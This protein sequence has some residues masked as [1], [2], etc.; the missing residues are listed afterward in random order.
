VTILRP[1]LPEAVTP[2]SRKRLTVASWALLAVAGFVVYLELARTRA[3]D[4]DGAANALQAWD[5]LHGNLLLRG[6]RVSDVSFYTTEL[7]QYMLIELVRGLNSGVV[8]IAAAMTYTLAVLTAALVAKGTATGREGVL[9]AVTA[10]GIMLAPQLGDG[11]NTLVSSPDHIG[12]AVPILLAW[13]ILERGGRRWYIAVAVALLLGWTTVGDVLTLYVGVAPVVLICAYRAVRGGPRWFEISLG[14]GTLACGLAAVGVL[15][16]IHAAGGF[17][18]F[19][20]HSQLAPLPE[21]LGHNLKVVADGLLLLGG[22]SFSGLSGRANYAFAALHFAGLAIAA[23]AF[24]VTAWCWFRSDLVDQIIVVAII[25]N[26]AGY[27]LTTD[28]VSVGTTREMNP[29]LPL[30]AALAGRRL[31]PVLLHWSKRRILVPALSLVLA[32]YAA[33]LA[34]EVAAPPAPPMHANLANWLVRH[35]LTSGLSGY[36]ASSV[37]TVTTGAGVR[38]VVGDSHQGRFAAGGL[39]TNEN[40]Y[41]PHEYRANFVVLYPSAGDYGGFN[42]R[43]QALASFG[44]PVRVYHAARCTIM[45]WNKNLLA[46]L[47]RRLPT[48]AMGHPWG[49]WSGAYRGEQVG[50]SVVDGGLQGAAQHRHHR[51][52]GR[53]DSRVRR[54]HPGHLG[55]DPL[56]E[57][58]PARE[59]HLPAEH[60]QPRIE[61]RAHRSDAERHPVRQF[62]EE[63]VGAG[64][65]GGPLGPL[66]PLGSLGGGDRGADRF[67]RR[68]R[69]EAVRAGQHADR[70]RASQPLQP[71]ARRIPDISRHRRTWHREVTD[72]ASRPG[73]TPVQLSAQHGR[74]S[75]ADPDPDQHEVIHA[76]G[77]TAGMLRHRGEVHVVLDHHGTTQRAAQ[78]GEHPLV[79]GRQVY[80]EPRVTGRRVHDPWRADDERAQRAHRHTGLAAGTVHRAADQLH[81]VG[82]VFRVLPDLGDHPAGYIGHGGRHQPGLHVKGGDI[83][84]GGHDRVERRVRAT[85][86][87]HLTRDVDQPAVL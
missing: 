38:I 21:I 84:T 35:H 64:S 30:A 87:R 81:R 53:Y 15:R 72:L 33:G 14:A 85:A 24:L 71:A 11:T 62:A 77:R 46:Q 60:H 23:G 54:A 86:T 41:N 47:A 28:A 45:V 69:G 63:L 2:R 1:G 66:G 48:A 19:W 29:V 12:T 37:T 27:L 42:E 39:E 36:W 70:F 65:G 5:M 20:P 82:P 49:R 50:A 78:F 55:P 67:T 32:G 10:A 76:R 59:P 80:R 83:G 57:L 79:P 4:S 34:Y 73:G 17:Y 6:W 18:M 68:R 16:L 56:G 8:H 52:L 40:W 43:R 44:R 9:R 61:H 58:R 13:L 51:H 74:Q 7:P 31:G 26:I 75:Q 25:M 3:V 22:A